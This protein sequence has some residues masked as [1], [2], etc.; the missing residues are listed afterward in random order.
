MYAVL[1]TPIPVQPTS[2]CLHACR[3]ALDHA[4]FRR[5]HPA[6]LI[7]LDDLG[8]QDIAP[9]AQ[10]W[11]S[12]RARVHGITQGLPN[13][14]D[15]GHQA[16][17]TDQ[18]GATCRTAADPLDQPPDQGQVTR[19]ADLTAHLQAR[20]A[21]HSQHHPHDTALFLDTQLIGLHLPQVP[22]LFDQ[23]LVH[24]LPLASGACPPSGD[25]P[26]V[27]PN[28][29]PLEWCPLPWGRPQKAAGLLQRR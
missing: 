19:R 18:Q 8:D 26:L 6:P 7:A 24:D 27:K 22:W 20:L 13:G 15:G 28:V 14:P 23:G 11:S 4:A 16:I 12:A 17:G 3:R 21:H 25:R 2:E 29:L 9:R 10:L 5:D 1:L